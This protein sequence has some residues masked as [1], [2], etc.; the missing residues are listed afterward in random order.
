M[1]SNHEKLEVENLA[2]HSSA[3]PCTPWSRLRSGM[4][5]FEYLG[6]TENILASLSGAQMGSNHGKK[7]EVEN[8]MT[9]SL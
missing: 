7:L 8:L 2:T 3:A 1:G 5:K 4:H 9:H 6:E